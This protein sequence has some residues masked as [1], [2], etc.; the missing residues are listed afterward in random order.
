M[1]TLSVLILSKKHRIYAHNH[2]NATTPTAILDMIH[3]L[4]NFSQQV[5]IMPSHNMGV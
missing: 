1:L 3:R 5:T 2:N 4:F